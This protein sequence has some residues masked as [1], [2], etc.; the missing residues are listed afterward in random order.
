M[1]DERLTE[2]E[3]ARLARVVQQQGGSQ[4]PLMELYS[5]LKLHAYEDPTV[6]PIR[7]LRNLLGITIS[8]AQKFMGR[9]DHALTQTFE[10]PEGMTISQRLQD[11]A[12]AADK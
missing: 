2:A 3:E 7:L 1:K 9:L 12:N 5:I 10:S 8:D 11:R 4:A 6:G